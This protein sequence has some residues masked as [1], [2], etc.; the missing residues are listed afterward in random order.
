MVRTLFKS[1]INPK[2]KAWKDTACWRNSSGCLDEAWVRESCGEVEVLQRRDCLQVN[3]KCS[4]EINEVEWK[5]IEFRMDLEQHGITWNE[6]TAS[7]Q[8]VSPRRHNCCV[9]VR[10]AWCSAPPQSC[11]MRPRHCWRLGLICQIPI[12]SD[13]M[14]ESNVC[15]GSRCLLWFYDDVEWFWQFL[16][17]DTV[18]T[19][20]IRIISYLWISFCKFWREKCQLGGHGDGTT[21]GIWATDHGRWAADGPDFANGSAVQGTESFIAKPSCGRTKTDE[22]MNE[23]I[24]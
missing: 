20:M 2:T 7:Q 11:C 9:A 16:T 15:K 10:N 8:M 19:C 21:I 3:Y 14:N 24:V 18:W 13:W 1:T 12:E 6:C 5:D 22:W 4:K 23:D 17:Y